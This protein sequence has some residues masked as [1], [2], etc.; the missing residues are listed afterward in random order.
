MTIQQD[1]DAIDATQPAQVVNQ[2][3]RF[4]VMRTNFS[5]IK[6]ALQ[7]ILNKLP[8]DEQIAGWNTALSTPVVY[9]PVTTNTIDSN[10]IHNGQPQPKYTPIIDKKGRALLT[11][12]KI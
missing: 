11:K 7:S 2:K 4:S 1:I 12:V 3:P 6:S 8:T 5:K 9:A 10:V